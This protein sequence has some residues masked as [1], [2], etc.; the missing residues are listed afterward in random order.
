MA[1]LPTSTSPSSTIF[2]PLLSGEADI[3]SELLS[4]PRLGSSSRPFSVLTPRGHFNCTTGCCGQ[5]TGSSLT[6]PAMLASTLAA[7][8]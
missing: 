1:V 5:A 3:L 4:G 6:K 8:S 7:H 2:V